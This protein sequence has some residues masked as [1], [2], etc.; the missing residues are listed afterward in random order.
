MTVV[1]NGTTGIT[2]PGMS[3]SG[4]VSLAGASVKVLN[5]S[6]NPVVQQTGSVLQVVSAT[7]ATNSSTTSATPVSTGLTASITPSSSSNK[8]L[9]LIDTQVTSVTTNGVGILLYR[10]ASVVKSSALDGGSHYYTNYVYSPTS[11]WVQQSLTYLDSPASSSSTT[12][13]VY[14]ASYNAGSA[15][16]MN[17]GNTPYTSTIT[18]L[19]IAA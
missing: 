2:T 15:V 18:L 10:G 16:A 3:S 17:G 6:G 8:V 1:I 4:N 12:Y 7:Y 19:E 11:Q 14:I 9:I 5:N 13:T